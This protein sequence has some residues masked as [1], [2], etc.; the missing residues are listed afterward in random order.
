MHDK[1]R[2]PIRTRPDGSIDTAHYMAVGRA[3][4][5]EAAHD[6]VRA[7]V[8]TPERRPGRRIFRVLGLL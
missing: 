6:M 4:R 5:S 1:T 8:G 7:A 2:D 3:C